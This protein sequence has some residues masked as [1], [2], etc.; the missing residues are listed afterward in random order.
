MDFHKLPC[1]AAGT[2]VAVNI[3]RDQSGDLSWDLD[4]AYQIIPEAV[5]NDALDH[6]LP[7]TSLLVE[8]GLTKTRK[9][10]VKDSTERDDVR[11]TVASVDTG[12]MVVS[13][14][15]A[16]IRTIT[17]RVKNDVAITTIRYRI[18]GTDAQFGPVLRY[19]DARVI[20]KA[21]AVQ[22]ALPFRQKTTVYD[23]SVGELV[24]GLDFSGVLTCGIVVDVRKDACDVQEMGGMVVRVS[25][26]GMGPSTRI[27]A[28]DHGS[29]GEWAEALQIRAKGT[30]IIA[31]WADVTVVLGQSYMQEG[32]KARDT[33]GAFI[34]N[35][36]IMDV[37]LNKGEV[38][39]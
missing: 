38:S 18:C 12:E 37:L 14:I 9:V 2:L 16:E 26:E 31:T 3:R 8:E 25:R 33:D 15:V 5:A 35:S 29:I 39:N 20:T 7:G 6:A 23:V 36:E 22:V 17:L 4:V 32:A 13:S 1:D 19:L 24:S 11:L 34:L 28:P 21:E 27:A 10:T 30:G